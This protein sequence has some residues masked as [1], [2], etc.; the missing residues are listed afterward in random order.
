MSSGVKSRGCGWL[1][2]WCVTCVSTERWQRDTRKYALCK[3][4]LCTACAAALQGQVYKREMPESAARL[5]KH[6]TA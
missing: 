4:P 5:L 3:L 6:G 2:C 1:W